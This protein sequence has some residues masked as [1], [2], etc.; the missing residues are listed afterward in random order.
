MYGAVF[1]G[2]SFLGRIFLMPV[3]TMVAIICLIQIDFRLTFLLRSLNVVFFEY[4]KLTS[5]S[6]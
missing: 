6:L 5:F 4:S 1:L 2:E 3:A